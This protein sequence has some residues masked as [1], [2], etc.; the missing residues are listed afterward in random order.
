MASHGNPSA[1]QPRRYSGQK[2]INR[3]NR[4][5]M[6]I[7]R[8]NFYKQN[9][10]HRTRNEGITINEQFIRAC[11]NGDYRTVQQMINTNQINNID[12]TNQL[13]RTAMQLAI[14]NEH[15]EVNSHT[16]A[17]RSCCCLSLFDRL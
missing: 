14:E 4:A 2:N 6:P 16:I 17:V 13:G 11:V 10:F 9:Y 8:P 3:R 1:L 12:A 15:L 5:E 7:N